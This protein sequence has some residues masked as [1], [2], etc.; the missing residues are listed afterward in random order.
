[1]LWVNL[2]MSFENSLQA[3]VVVAGAGPA[4]STAA[5]L[6]AARGWH[7]L[8]VDRAVFPRNKTCGDGLTPRAI[9]VL[10]RLGVLAALKDSGHQ[11]V[12]GARL[13]APDETEWHLDF[14]EHNLELPPFG[15]VIPRHTL[16][17]V[18]CQYAVTRGAQFLPGV[19]ATGP[20]RD[21]AAVVGLQ[22][23]IGD[24]LVSLIAPLTILATGANIGLLRAFG[25]LETMPPGINAVRG[26]FAGVPDLADELEF[27]FD[28]ALAPGYG[29]VF[30]LGDGRANIGLGTPVRSGA[31]SAVPPLHRRMAEF[32]ARH[33]RLQAARSEGPLSGYP[34]RTDYPSCR[35]YGGGFLLAGEAA[36]LVN[37]VTGE[38]IDLALESAEL[39]A[40]V[41][42]EALRQG[43]TSSRRLAPYDSAL[44][45]RYAGF[46]RGARLLLRL[47]TGPRAINILIRQALRK[48]HL[49][50]V[51]AG[52]NTG[53]ISPYAA[54]TPRVWWDILT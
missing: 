14:S 41:A 48:P 46:F 34:L 51:I 26:Y 50:N 35:S 36:G 8:L 33:P 5:A 44:Y 4:G 39:A 2:E 30:P 12:K 17:R 16:D 11:V 28:A 27:Y 10:E 49:A 18:L 43:D 9:P 45:A 21:G 37:P 15:L 47:A 53:T 52:I 22:G 40:K 19:H 25:L 6:L 42:D 24:R 13:I 29:W 38:G 20:L 7:V 1:M 54:F 23:R 3:D 32:L 31:G